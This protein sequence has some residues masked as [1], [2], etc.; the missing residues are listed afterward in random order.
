LKADVV[1]LGRS[2]AELQDQLTLTARG[3]V[4]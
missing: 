2:F 3:S 1:K 4:N